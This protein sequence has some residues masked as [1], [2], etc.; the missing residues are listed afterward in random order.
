[1][2]T[3]FLIVIAAF[4]LNACKSPNSNY[5]LAFGSCNKQDA[6]QSYWNVI[7]QQQPDVFIWGGDNIYADTSNLDTLKAMYSKQKQNPFYQDFLTSIN[8]HVY[9]T[10]DDHDY[11]LNDGGKEWAIKDQ[12]EAL[13]LDFL[14]V[15]DE[16]RRAQRGI[17]HAT[18]IMQGNHSIKI[19]V[20]DTRYFR[21]S[22]K[23]STSKN[24][25]YE[26]WDVPNGSILGS[27][28]WEWLEQEIATSEADF[29]VIVS[30]IQFLSAEHG[31]ET[32]GNF[33]HE[34]ERLKAILVKHQLK[35]TVL[36]SGDRHISEFS[37]VEVEGLDYDLYDFT[38]S[39]LTHSY[40]GFNGEP[41]RNRVGEV[42][43]QTSFG[44]LNF[45]FDANE[46]LLEMRSTENAEVLQS[47]TLKF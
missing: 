27:T 39:G 31:F 42:I 20:L 47:E 9:A 45:D 13:F 4:V 6:N 41:N 37:S 10:W 8:H 12:S 18:E 38:S 28:Q 3:P 33:P 46:V 34:L 23:L 17:Y 40:S 26:P 11:G 14:D 19:Y 29:N 7:Q 30:S 32:W 25:R 43:H 36:L 5:V 16:N 35:N 15:T 2:R 22:L 44:L 21:D 1:M 24:K